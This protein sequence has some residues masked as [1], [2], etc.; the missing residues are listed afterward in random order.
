[1]SLP[2]AL[3]TI[4][5]REKGGKIANKRFAYQARWALS[6]AIQKHRS[7]DD[8]AV[9]VEFHDDVVLLN[10]PVSPT[11]LAFYQVKTKNKGTW[12]IGP[13]FTRDKKKTGS[14]SY[15]GKL[16]D[17]FRRF[18]KHTASLNFVTNLP[19]ASLDPDVADQP[20]NACKKSEDFETFK[21]KL[22]DECS[23]ATD[24]HCDI[25]RFVLSDLSL[26]DPDTHTLGKLVQ[27]ITEEIGDDISFNPTKLFL[28]FTNEF[29]RRSRADTPTDSLASLVKAKAVTRADVDGWLNAVRHQRP[30]PKWEDVSAHLSCL[31]PLE[32]LRLRKIWARYEVEVLNAGDEALQIVRGMVREAIDG[33]DQSWS[34]EE[35]LAYCVD[36]VREKGRK[37]ID[38]LTDDKLKVMTLYEALADDTEP[39]I[40]AAD[41]QPQDPEE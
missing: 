13:L 28:I 38:G 33:C 19:C 35:I 29:E 30:K 40:Q 15:I 18:P 4:P 32:L 37:I 34:W 8:Y 27:F 14:A 9:A 1:M 36:A 23:E 3:L 31:P 41:A 6:L 11:S 25:F 26:G 24:E 20:F 17:N 21:K 2:S 5:E 39:E 12:T 7:G 10:D 22:L 16:F